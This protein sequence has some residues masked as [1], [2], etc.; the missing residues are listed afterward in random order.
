MYFYIFQM[1]RGSQFKCILCAWTFDKVALKCQI[2]I[3]K[4]TEGIGHYLQTWKAKCTCPNSTQ[5]HSTMT[6]YPDC[7]W[8]QILGHDEYSTSVLTSSLFQRRISQKCFIF[9]KTHVKYS[10][11]NCFPNFEKYFHTCFIKK[12]TQC[13]YY[14][15]FDPG[16][17]FLFITLFLSSLL[18]LIQSRR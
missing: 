11:R 16:L 9:H 13:E 18:I 17:Y 7:L 4:F 8:W 6:M 15:L 12:H 3:N 2:G 14:A 5:L 10:G 1:C